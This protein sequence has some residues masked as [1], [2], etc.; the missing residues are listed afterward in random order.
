V[1]SGSF[2]VLKG[3][4]TAILWSAQSVGSVIF[5]YHFFSLP[6]PRPCTQTAGARG[7]ERRLEDNGKS[8]TSPISPTSLVAA[9][10]PM[11]SNIT[12]HIHW[13]RHR[14]WFAALEVESGKSPRYVVGLV[15]CAKYTGDYSRGKAFLA[16][17][18]P[19]GGRIRKSGRIGYGLHGV[20]CGDFLF[21]RLD[22]QVGPRKSADLD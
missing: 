10:S 16:P 2:R 19:K 20:S 17:P 1:V 6:T 18:E 11:R 3:R 4:F 7:K 15:W 12:G 9:G 13:D 14:D 8:L 22:N 5:H 21:P